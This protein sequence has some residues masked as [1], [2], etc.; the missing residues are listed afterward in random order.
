MYPV[1]S[2][3][4]GNLITV[5]EAAAEIDVTSILL[6]T[7]AARGTIEKLKVAKISKMFFDDGNI[8]NPR[9]M[10]TPLLAGFPAKKNAGSTFTV[11]KVYKIIVYRRK[12]E[13]QV[14]CLVP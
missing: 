6:F 4:Q 8:W 1:V 13:H 7:C 14:A 11:V 5:S 10:P 12:Q 3:T 9:T 2:N